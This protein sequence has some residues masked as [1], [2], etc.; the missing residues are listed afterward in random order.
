MIEISEIDES[1]MEPLVR[2]DAEYEAAVFAG[3]I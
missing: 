2:N 1:F 3:I